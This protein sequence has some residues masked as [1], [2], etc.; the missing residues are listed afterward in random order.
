MRSVAPLDPEA[1]LFYRKFSSIMLPDR[2]KMFLPM[3]TI[4]DLFQ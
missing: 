1:A 2:G 3:R 4:G